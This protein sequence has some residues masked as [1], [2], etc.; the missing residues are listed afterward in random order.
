MT[1]YVDIQ[2]VRDYGNGRAAEV[3]GPPYSVYR[4]G[5]ESNGDFI[6]E[7]NLIAEDIPVYKKISNEVRTFAETDVRLGTFWFDL[8]GDFSQFKTGDVFKLTDE[9]FAQGHASVPFDTHEL[10]AFCLAAHGT[11]RKPVGARINTQIGILRQASSLDADGNYNPTSENAQ[12]VKLVDGQFIL[13]NI[14]EQPDL[15]PAGL[16][17]AGR[18]YFDKTAENVPGMPRTSGW[19]CYVPP[20]NGFEFREGDRIFQFDGT[21]D[22]EQNGARYVVLVAYGQN[23]GA[24][25]WQ[26]FLERVQDQGG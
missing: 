11:Y 4:I 5:E 8:T 6:A 22:A 19:L 12:P 23:T 18:T 26:L 15:I 16:M 20:L 9:V 7:G 3:L 13:A 17:A 2:D 24:V 10:T 21:P 25:G 1:D 14:G